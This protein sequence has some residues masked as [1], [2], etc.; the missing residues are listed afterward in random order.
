[1]RALSATPCAARV[2]WLM[3]NQAPA[4]KGDGKLTGRSPG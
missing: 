2:R 1:M 4:S 3:T